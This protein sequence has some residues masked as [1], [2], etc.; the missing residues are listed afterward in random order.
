MKIRVDTLTPFQGIIHGPNRTEPGC[1][2]MGKSGLKTYL[3]IDLARPEGALGSCGVKYN[4]RTEERRLA[5]AVRAH[6]TIEL[7][8]DSVCVRLH[9]VIALLPLADLADLHPDL[10]EHT[11][12]H[13]Y[14]RLSLD[15][16]ELSE[17]VLHLYHAVGAV[18]RISHVAEHIPGL[19]REDADAILLLNL[20]Q[21]ELRAL[22]GAASVFRV[23]S[24]AIQ[25]LT[26]QL[27]CDWDGMG[28][29]DAA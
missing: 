3:N 7:L 21:F 10:V 4:Q 26:V 19:T 13:P 29:D 11:P 1:S 23:R 16:V 12:I 20:Q 18:D 24:K 2:V 27:A 15:L 5:L 9:Y 8:E 28:T 14:S 6:P 25:L 22:F 17:S